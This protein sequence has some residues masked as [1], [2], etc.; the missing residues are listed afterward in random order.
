MPAQ[1]LLPERIGPSERTAGVMAGT[2]AAAAGVWIVASDRLLG[3]L[4]ADVSTLTRLQTLKGWFFVAATALLFFIFIRRALERMRLTAERLSA[5]EEKF[6][7]LVERSLAGI[8]VIQDGRFAYVNARFANIFGYR[9]EDVVGR[10][11]VDDLV[12]PGDRALVAENLRKRVSGEILYINYQFRGVRA[13]GAPVDVEVAGEQ[14]TVGGRPAVIGTLLDHT[15]RNQLQKQALET[16]K[17]ETLGLLAGGIVHDF[18]NVVGA[19]TGHAELMELELPPGSDARRNA[20]EIR[21][22]AVQASILTRQLLTF[23]RRQKLEAVPV[24][25]NAAVRDCA[26]MLRSAAGPAVRLDLNLEDGL[27]SVRAAPGQIEQA[28]MNLVINARDAMTGGGVVAVATRRGALSV[29][30][31]PDRPCAMLS[32]RD[33]G[34]GMDRETLSRVF[35]VF[36]TTKAQG[37]GTGLG[38]PTVQRIAENAGGRVEI[39]SSPG[40]GTTVRVLLPLADPVIL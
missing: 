27:G 8:Y 12:S 32:V 6:R 18:G 16:Q 28:L 17:L 14:T 21:D 24:D 13:D 22:C 23:S 15:E 30:G 1:K 31:G 38:L 5:S 29:P 2:Y 3:S 7:T 11:S 20:E 4:P 10:L 25:L 33:T 37:K 34:T 9:P 26:A 19:I 40:I 39:D 36:F 35:E